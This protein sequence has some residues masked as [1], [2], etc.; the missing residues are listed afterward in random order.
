MV[1]NDLIWNSISEKHTRFPRLLVSLVESEMLSN[2]KG[3]GFEMTLQLGEGF[4]EC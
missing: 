3:L 2:F 4:F 1:S